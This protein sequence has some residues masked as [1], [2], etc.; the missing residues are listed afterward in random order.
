VRIAKTLEW[1]RGRL[2]TDDGSLDLSARRSKNKKGRTLPLRGPLLDLI[3]QRAAVRRLDCPL[4]L[5]RAGQPIR[6]FCRVWSKACQEAGVGGG[7]S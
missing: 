2:G 3:R 6:D 5:H 7:A 4:V 1:R